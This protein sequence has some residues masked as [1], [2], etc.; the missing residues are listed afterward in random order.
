MLRAMIRKRDG[1]ASTGWSSLGGGQLYR[2]DPLGG[3]KYVFVFVFFVHGDAILEARDA[4]VHILDVF[5]G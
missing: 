1:R 4:I 5:F 2:K 3:S